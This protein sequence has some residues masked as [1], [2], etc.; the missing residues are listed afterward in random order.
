M[1]SASTVYAVPESEIGNIGIR[2][3]VC[4]ESV[5]LQAGETMHVMS[6]A[7]KDF[8]FNH[9]GSLNYEAINMQQKEADEAYMRFVQLVASD[10]DIPPETIKGWGG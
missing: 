8:C 3:G 4:S 6:G 9:D 5:D 7:G 10:R 1:G 2:G